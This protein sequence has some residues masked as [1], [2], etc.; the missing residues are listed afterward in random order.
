MFPL[1]GRL[2]LGQP[3][4]A[5]PPELTQLGALVDV[6]VI[7]TGLPELTVVGE[8][9]KAAETTGHLSTTEA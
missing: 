1:A 4:F 7:V 8:A 5:P 2:E 6:Q 3:S 9:D